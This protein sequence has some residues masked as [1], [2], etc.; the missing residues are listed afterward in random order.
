VGALT[1][2]V[3]PWPRVAQG[4]FL[5]ILYS[6]GSKPLQIW[7]KQVQNGHIKRLTDEDIQSSVLEIMGTNV[8]NAARAA[9]PPPRAVPGMHARAAPR[10]PLLRLYGCQMHVR[11]APLAQVSTTYVACPADAGQTLGIKMPFLVMIIKNMR[12]YFSFEVQAR[13]LW[14]VSARRRSTRARPEAG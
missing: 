3:A 2:R 7:D 8:R 10:K 12:K 9:V 5:S 14:R 1:R 11:A 4:G 6:I 13:A